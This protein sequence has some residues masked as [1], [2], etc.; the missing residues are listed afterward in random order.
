[1]AAELSI[2]GLVYGVRFRSESRYRYVGLTTKTAQVRLRQHWTE[3]AAGRRTPFYDWL[4]KHDRNDVVVDYLDW[5]D[6]LD[7]LGEA[8]TARIALLRHEGH[9]LL[10]L[11]AGGL[12]PTG[13]EWTASARCSPKPS[14]LY[15][16]GRGSHRGPASTRATRL[17]AAS[18]T[19]HQCNIIH[20]HLRRDPAATRQNQA[21]SAERRR[22]L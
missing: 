1:M 3:A 21:Q 5:A 6:E 9:P 14:L 19:L 2:A 7:E 8:E 11:A 16:R 22:I 15:R 12:G 18:S 10:N 4:R 17:R 20:F 13:M